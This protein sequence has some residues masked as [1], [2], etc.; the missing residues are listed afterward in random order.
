MI[1]LIA[2]AVVAVAPPCLPYVD[3]PNWVWSTPKM[4]ITKNG[5]WYR[6][7]CWSTVP[8]IPDRTITYVGTVPE[9]SKIGGRV[10]T[11][12]K[13]ADPLKSL[14]TLPQR[15]TVLPLT[16]PSLSAIAADLPK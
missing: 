5:A 4:G 6:W 13:A 7:T 10:A 14:Q 11:I 1:E 16:D 2:A 12:V 9:F 15:I 3:T 8:G